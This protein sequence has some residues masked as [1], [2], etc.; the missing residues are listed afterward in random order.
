MYVCMCVSVYVC[1][2]VCACLCVKKNDQEKHQ[3]LLR[4]EDLNTP[5]PRLNAQTSCQVWPRRGGQ[6]RARGEVKARGLCKCSKTRRIHVGL[7]C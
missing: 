7:F 5:Q 6:V 4:G 1:V 2:C 3:I